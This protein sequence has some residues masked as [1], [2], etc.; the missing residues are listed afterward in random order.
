[1]QT[2]HPEFANALV[3]FPGIEA[4]VSGQTQ[5][6]AAVMH[7]CPRGKKHWHGATPTTA[8]T[9]I[10][11]QESQNGKNVEWLEKVTDEQYLCLGLSQ[12]RGAGIRRTG[13]TD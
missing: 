6:E 10:A 4:L 12:E 3:E 11:I 1:V 7:Q 2:A 5:I 13:H 9:H 8:M